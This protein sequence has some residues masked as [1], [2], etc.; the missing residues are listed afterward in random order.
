LPMKV[1][2]GK[3]EKRK[4]TFKVKAPSAK[5][6]VLVGDFS[7]WNTKLH[8]MKKDKEDFWKV[9]VQLAPGKYEYKLLVDGQ[10]WENIP[11]GSG[12]QN[13]FGTLNKLLFVAEK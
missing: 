1:S 3:A 7:N 10:W 13:P 9:T 8:P 11:A 4:V 5:E 2:T 6:V 12:V